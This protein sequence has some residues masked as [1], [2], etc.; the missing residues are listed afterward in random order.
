MVHT[1]PV[2]S[3]KVLNIFIF[4]AKIRKLTST[5]VGTSCKCGHFSSNVYVFRGSY[6]VY[7]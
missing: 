7:S 4:T 1:L 2:L 3:F 5:E 6:L